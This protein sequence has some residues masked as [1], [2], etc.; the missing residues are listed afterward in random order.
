PAPATSAHAALPALDAELSLLREAQG[1]LRAGEPARALALLDAAQ[2]AG[3][4]LGEERDAARVLAL[5]GAGRVDD[6]RR[7]AARFL[8]RRACGQRASTRARGDRPS[9][10]RSR[11]GDQVRDRGRTTLKAL[12]RACYLVGVLDPALAR[13]FLEGQA[14]AA[15][16]SRRDALPP[17]QSLADA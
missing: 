6:A 7:E 14:E 9:E 15:A 3:G 11:S 2:P 4:A 13:R 12:A 16:R 8:A 1:A 10:R 5:C 17:A